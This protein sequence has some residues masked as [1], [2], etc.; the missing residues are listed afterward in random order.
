MF[1]GRGEYKIARGLTAK[2][3]ADLDRF[4][5]ELVH[6]S[7]PEILGH[8]AV[9]WARARGLPVVA[10]L[11]TRFETY[12]R[13]YGIGFVEPLLIRLLTPLLQPRGPRARAEP[14]HGDVVAGV[15]RDDADQHLVARHRPRSLQPGPP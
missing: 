3:R 8:R 2:V 15:G 1:G 6:V 13:Y 12:M 11:H 14:E 4:A 5:P 10:S 9:S 7:A